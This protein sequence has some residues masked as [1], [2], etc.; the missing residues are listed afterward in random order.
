[1]EFKIQSEVLEIQ[2]V[3]PKQVVDWGV[4]LVQAPQLWS[5]T[6]GE[7]IKIAVLDTGI[8]ATHPDLIPNFKKG[9]NFT[10]S[11][12][13]DYFDKQGHGKTIV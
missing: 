3:A 5:T 9:R 6:K 2:S 7:G 11:N 12:V 4:S 10:N 13:M 1:M 8:D